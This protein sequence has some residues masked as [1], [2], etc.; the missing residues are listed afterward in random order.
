L[1][2]TVLQCAWN[3]CSQSWQVLR[4]FTRYG[5]FSADVDK[6]GVLEMMHAVII[7]SVQTENTI[8]I[9]SSISRSVLIFLHKYKISVFSKILT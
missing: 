4:C 5:G 2:L 9:Q 3:S 7:Y 1:F 6:G 8:P